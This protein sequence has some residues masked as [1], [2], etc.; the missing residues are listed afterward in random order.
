MRSSSIKIILF[1]GFL[2]LVACNG[3][4]D[5]TN[6]ELIQDMMDQI[7]LKAQDWD[8]LRGMEAQRTPP[9]HTVPR[10]YDPDKYDELSTAERNLKNPLAGDFSPPV[11]EL[12]R[13]K[14]QV[15]C[16]VC[17]GE[18]GDGQSAVGAKMTVPP[19]NLLE[20]RIRNF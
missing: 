12:G 1:A 18:K 2:A 14:Y 10:G 11:I 13:A 7:S 16:M 4:K 20:P 17:H 19:R 3:G 15:Y 9:E 5:Q 6:I 8:S